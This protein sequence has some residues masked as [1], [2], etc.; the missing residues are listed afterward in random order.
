MFS[1]QNALILADLATHITW[2]F[3]LFLWVEK[4][5]SKDKLQF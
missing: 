4:V 5:D 1:L 2:F 3:T